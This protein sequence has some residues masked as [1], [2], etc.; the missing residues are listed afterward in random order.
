MYLTEKEDRALFTAAAD[1]D[2][3]AVRW[4]IQNGADVNATDKYGRTALMWAAGSPAIAA[5]TVNTASLVSSF[6]APVMSPLTP[7]KSL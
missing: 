5:I 6:A 3:A 1:G 2:L 4:Y 7:P